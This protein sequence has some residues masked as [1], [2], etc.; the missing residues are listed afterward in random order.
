VDKKINRRIF[1]WIKELDI[2]HDGKKGIHD[3]ILKDK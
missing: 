3:R 1:H 2:N